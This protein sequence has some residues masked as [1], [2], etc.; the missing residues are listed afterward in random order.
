MTELS[1]PTM[2][3]E[4]K[5]WL[6]SSFIGSA[7]MLGLLFLSPYVLPEE[8]PLGMVRG[9]VG[10]SITAVFSLVILTGG[11]LFLDRVTPKDYLAKI[12]DDALAC[13]VLACGFLYSFVSLM[14][15]M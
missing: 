10:R 12:E 4:I 15:Y 8:D 13:A 14:Q 7:V 9:V 5:R 3:G 1:D 11:L 6:I 2:K